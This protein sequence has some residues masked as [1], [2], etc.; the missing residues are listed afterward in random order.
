MAQMPNGLRLS[1]SNKLSHFFVDGNTTSPRGFA[2]EL[3][4][5]G[6]AEICILRKVLPSEFLN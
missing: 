5:E 6:D 2:P 1:N 3:V 4:C